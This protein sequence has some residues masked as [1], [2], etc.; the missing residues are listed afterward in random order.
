[1]NHFHI[2]HDLRPPTKGEDIRRITSGQAEAALISWV[3]RM[4]IEE[5]ARLVSK[6]AINDIEG[7]REIKPAVQVFLEDSYPWTPG[8]ESH[9]YENGREMPMPPAD[10]TM[11]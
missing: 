5:M 2:K 3:K 4:D 6:Y 11:C 9:P 10:P 8:C 1:M 7:P